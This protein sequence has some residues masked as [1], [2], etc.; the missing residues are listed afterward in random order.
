MKRKRLAAATAAL[1][2]AL[3]IAVVL[4]PRPDAAPPANIAPAPSPQVARPPATPV[5]PAPPQVQTIAFADPAACTPA[6]ALSA[7]LDQMTPTDQT[8]RP[9]Q[10]FAP[11]LAPMH[12]VVLGT[13]QL[14]SDGTSHRVNVRA[15]ASWHGLTLIGLSRW[16]AEESDYAGFALHFAEPPQQ[17]IAVLN[18]QGFALPPSGS[19]E[20]GV[21][22]QT[23]L[24]VTA[25]AAGASFSCST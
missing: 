23:F 21:E 1:S 11:Q 15:Q 16:W 7:L 3:G 22:L 13:P 8:G 5:L 17:V 14:V 4:W 20:Q 12:D 9:V 19:R 24:A 25:E 10:P 6:P 2:V 18:G